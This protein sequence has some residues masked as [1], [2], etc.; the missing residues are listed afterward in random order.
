VVGI[1]NQL[2]VCLVTTKVK[3][4]KSILSMNKT[5][6]HYVCTFQYCTVCS[7]CTVCCF[8]CWLQ[9]EA[10]IFSPWMRRPARP[11]LESNRIFEVEL[12]APLMHD[13]D[14][15]SLAGTLLW[16]ERANENIALLISRLILLQWENSE[17]EA[18]RYVLN[19][20]AGEVQSGFREQ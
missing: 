19:K 16:W 2:A 10:C 3:E 7:N 4:K 17:K 20:C 8:H 5:F 1:V 13:S 9:A 11:Q 6:Q 18:Y 15:N 12:H 14:N